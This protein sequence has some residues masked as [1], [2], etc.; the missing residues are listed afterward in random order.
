MLTHRSD[1]FF[2]YRETLIPKGIVLGYEVLLWLVHAQAQGHRLVDLSRITN[3]VLRHLDDHFLIAGS[4]SITGQTS[5]VG[6]GM[7]TVTPYF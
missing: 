6:I 3:L 4:R 5:I 2:E 1:G 7:Q